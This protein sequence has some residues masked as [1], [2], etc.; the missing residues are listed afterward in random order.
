MEDAEDAENG[1][2]KSQATVLPEYHDGDSVST[3]TNETGHLQLVLP[4]NPNT[5]HGD[6]FFRPLNDNI[7]VQP[8]EFNSEAWTQHVNDMG[9]TLLSQSRPENVPEIVKDAR[10]AAG[11]M[12]R[13]G[14]ETFEKYVD[15]ENDE[16]DD[17][18]DE[19]YFH[20]RKK[21]QKGLLGG[22]KENASIRKHRVRSKV[23][24]KLNYAFKVISNKLLAG[25]TRESIEVKLGEY[26]GFS[27]EEC[28]QAMSE[29]PK[30]GP[31]DSEVL[32]FLE[33]KEMYEG[34]AAE[35][36]KMRTETVAQLMTR[37]NVVKDRIV[38]LERELK[39]TKDGLFLIEY[40]IE[41]KAGS[42]HAKELVKS[43]LVKRIAQSHNF[44]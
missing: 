25:E 8:P 22:A 21:G 36:E 9:E 2:E 12:I 34:G 35:F 39:K 15:S 10:R 38:Q 28:L 5:N 6:P 30:F 11:A 32:N 20:P 40:A 1:D 26:F 7:A 4:P 29:I 42:Q 14:K 3:L 41:E 16:E 33:L 43:Y 23:A 13:T 19:D 44:A 31:S 27:Y 24:K 18:T 17:P 37:S